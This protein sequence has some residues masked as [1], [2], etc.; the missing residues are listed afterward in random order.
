MKTTK[1]YQPK[2]GVKCSCK[3]GIERDNCARCEGTGMQIDFKKIREQNAPKFLTI[4]QAMKAGN[5]G[6][7][8]DIK[9][10]FV[11]REVYCNVNS[12]VEYCLSTGFE[13]SNSPVNFD[14]LENY[15]ILPEWSKTVIGEDLFFEGGTE[16]DREQFLEEFDRLTE[17]SETLLSEETISEATH[18]RNIEQIEEA[19]KEVE[20]LES[21]P[22]EVFE[23]WAVSSFLFDKL[24]DLGHVVIDT[25]SCKVWGRT[26]TGQAILLDYSITK[27]CAEMKI[28][29]GQEN[30][31]ERK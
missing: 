27:I 5:D 7:N 10:Q 26:T 18:E 14:D 22:Q 8:Q 3:K 4:E 1:E 31:W 9:S 23:W 25:G 6:K 17:E 20:D 21:E 2:T 11:G 16:K 19:K 28:L 24:R 29:E 30:S 12:L 13:D 15:Y